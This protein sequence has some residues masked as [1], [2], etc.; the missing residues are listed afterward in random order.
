M[1]VL[2]QGSGAQDAPQALVRLKYLLKREH[3]LAL[4]QHR[5][6]LIS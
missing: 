3:M 6:L 2:L 1:Q 4:R 5:Y